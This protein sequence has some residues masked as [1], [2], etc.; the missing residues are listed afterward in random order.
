MKRKEFFQGLVFSLIWLLVMA[1]NGT[2][3]T[4][5]S[6][7]I[8]S[9]TTW[10]LAN[11]PYIVIKDVQIPKG[12]ALTIEPGVTVKYAG[13]YEILVKGRI[14]ANG[15]A[16]QKITFT[17]S[18]LNQ[19]SGATQIRFADTDLSLSQISYVVMEWAS[20]AIFTSIG[21]SGTLNFS[22][23]ELFHNTITQGTN[24]YTSP[25]G[26][27]NI[28]L[29]NAT[30]SNAIVEVA[31]SAL[32]IQD[33]E[34]FDSTIRLNYASAPGS[35]LIQRCKLTRTTMFSDRDAWGGP[36]DVSDSILTDSKIQC[37][38]VDCE[39]ARCSLVNSY[40]IG[41]T[42]GTLTILDTVISY[43]SGPVVDCNTGDY[44]KNCSVQHS[45]II[46]GGSNIGIDLTNGNV[47]DTLIQDTAK[48]I[49]IAPNQYV[50]ASGASV[51][52]SNLINASIYTIEN[53]TTKDISALNNYWGTADE[54]MI[55]QKIFDYYD[56][57]NFGKVIY[58]PFLISPDTTAPISPPTGLSAT[59]GAGDITLEWSA[60]PESDV[61]GYKVY[62][63]TQPASFFEKVVDVGNSTSY[64]LP[65]DAYY[66]GVTAY[67][68]D[69]A[70][71]NDDPDTIV[72]E[73]QTN[74]N[75][76]W[77]AIQETP[78]IPGDCN[79]DGTVSIDEIQKA[80]NCFLSKQNACC[81]K[82]DLNS[83]GTVSI[84]E[85]QRVINAY[86]GK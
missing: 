24:S 13:A 11:S 33:S 63:G 81:D 85:V 74:G 20:R 52:N 25:R 6:G 23:S 69:Y 29:S 10:I 46:G 42:G 82:C 1:N 84:N 37:G 73:N 77:Y 49:R 35:I 14:I 3:D 70:E 39:V 54:N 36:M 44:A 45:T 34:I 47:V 15:T 30:I 60:N 26:S 28:T 16:S 48:A 67:D 68:T 71:A 61:A 18:Q 55:K 19:S 27:G 21:N 65:G 80:I 75:E 22:N 38:C 4:P 17:S 32:K 9:D 58:F 7:I 53:R 83:D 50:I 8:D 78:S 43:G 72:N 86:L 12:V 31:N 51:T 40:V 56:D 41:F 76:S 79:S 2:A 59:Q 66:I 62:W 5:V 57:I 64:T